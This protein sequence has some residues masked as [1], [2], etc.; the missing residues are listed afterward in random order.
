MAV[1]LLHY[2]IKSRQDS[3]LH[4]LSHA[5][6]S[7]ERKINMYLVYTAHYMAAFSRWIIRVPGLQVYRMILSTSKWQCII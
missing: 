7:I 2:R 5:L 4:L 6:D 1:S 3:Y